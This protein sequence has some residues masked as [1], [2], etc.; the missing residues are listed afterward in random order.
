VPVAASLGCGQ[1]RPPATASAKMNPDEQHQSRSVHDQAGN[2]R[3]LRR[4]HVHPLEATAVGMATL[5]RRQRLRRRCRHGVTLQVVEPHLNGPGGDVPIIVHDIKR[6]RTEVIAA[7][8]PP[9]RCNHRALPRRGSGNGAR[10]GA[11]AACVPG[12][13]N[14]GCC[15][16]ATTARAAARRA[17]AGHR[18]RRDGYP[19]GS[20]HRDDCDRRQMFRKH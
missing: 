7:R 13:S 15:C 14:P 3:H 16:C 17:R 6:G 2:R 10:H 12:T 5:E 19:L 18:L 1:V 4:R 9:V 11:L 20:A 8:A